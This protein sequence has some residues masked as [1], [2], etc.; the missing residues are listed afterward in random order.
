MTKFFWED[1]IGVN[2]DIDRHRKK[3]AELAVRIAELEVEVLTDPDA[4][5]WLRTYR[6][7][8][9]QL[10]QSKADAVNKLGRK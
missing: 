2:A 7:L 9:C 4:E 1:N 10:Q 6:H 8:M 5:V 3:E